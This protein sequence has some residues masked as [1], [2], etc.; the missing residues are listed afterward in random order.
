MSFLYTAYMGKKEKGQINTSLGIHLMVDAYECPH[1]ILDDMKISYEFLDKLPEKIGMK[2]L[3]IPYVI[4]ADAND[5]KDPGGW[6]GF[7]I[8]AESHI[9]V[10]T[11]PKRGFVTIDVYSCKGFDTKKTLDH[12]QKVFQPKE[13][14]SITALRGK[15]YPAKN[16][17]E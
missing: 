2:K 8:I 15:K 14:D 10:H 5:K 9:S 16:I 12:I 11:F 6:T 7:V 13:I 4:H 3:T 17:Y 1:A